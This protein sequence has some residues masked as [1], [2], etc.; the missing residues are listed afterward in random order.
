ML[1]SLSRYDVL[2]IEAGSINGLFIQENISL[3]TC[4]VE[5]VCNYLSAPNDTIAIHDNATGCDSQEEVAE[6]CVESV[7]ENYL[8][9]GAKTNPNPFSTSTTIEYQLDHSSEVTVSI[10]NHLGEQVEIIRQHQSSGQ[11]HVTWDA[12]GLP[13]GVY[14]FT[15]KAGD[16]V[17]FGKMVLMK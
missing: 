14:F 9:R 16:Q 7:E 5:S 6:A 2:H 8:V 12:S 13:S 10:F 1:F 11:Q 4:E 15:L 17:A 3:A